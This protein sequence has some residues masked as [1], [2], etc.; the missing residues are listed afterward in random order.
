MYVM[1]LFYEKGEGVSINLQKAVKWYQ[2]AAKYGHS[3]AKEKLKE[4]I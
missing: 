4:F 3:K 1:G 2:K